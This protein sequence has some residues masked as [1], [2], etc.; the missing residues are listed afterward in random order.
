MGIVCFAGIPH[1]FIRTQCTQLAGFICACRLVRLS[2]QAA[3]TLL[4][5]L[6]AAIAAHSVSRVAAR[7]RRGDGRGPPTATAAADGAPVP[8]RRVSVMSQHVVQDD[9]S[10]MLVTDASGHYMAGAVRQATACQRPES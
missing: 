5:E 6:R 8:S 4:S 2:C 9:S 7:V 10:G 1:T 3:D